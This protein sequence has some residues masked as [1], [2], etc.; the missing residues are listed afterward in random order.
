M[1]DFD[2]DSLTKI[3]K[4]IYNSIKRNPGIIQDDN[5]SPERNFMN[6]KSQLDNLSAWAIEDDGFVIL[7]QP[8]TKHLARCHFYSENSTYNWL[9]AGKRITKFIFDN[10]PFQKV[11]NMFGDRRMSVVGKRGGWKHEGVIE[12]AYW[13][14]EKYTDLYI[15]S[16]SRDDYDKF[17]E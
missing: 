17:C 15:G 10:F 11:Y 3:E 4:I 13:D 7:I 6:I 2:Y 16:V 5:V 1:K 8:E 12:R 9:K 14:G